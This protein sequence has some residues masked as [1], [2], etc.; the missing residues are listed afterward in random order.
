MKTYRFIRL[1]T[2][3]SVLVVSGC[4]T[5]PEDV[6]TDPNSVAVVVGS[7]IGT[8][9]SGS[10][11]GDN[12]IIGLTMF[13]HNTFDLAEGSA[14]N[15]KYTITSGA[16]GIFNAADNASIIYFPKDGSTVDF[17]S[18]YPYTPA[19]TSDYI[20]PLN[21][22]DQTALPKIDFMTADHLAGD[23]KSNPAVQLRFHH[24]LSKLV[25]NLQTQTG[26]AP[27][28]LIGSTITIKGMYTQGSYKLTNNTSGVTPNLTSMGD[29]NII[30]NASGVSAEGIVFPRAA[31]QGIVFEVTLT[32]GSRYTAYMENTLELK[33]GYQYIFY[34]TLNKTPVVVSADIQPWN[35]GPTSNLT[36]LSIAATINASSGVN[37][38]DI[39]HVYNKL[40]HI[41]QYTYGINGQW[42]SS[43]P[44]Y[45]ENLEGSSATFRAAINP[46][47]A[48]NA[49][50]LPDILVADPV[51]VA[52]NDGVNFIFRHA[53]SKV[54]VQLSSSDGSFTSTELNSATISLPSYMTGGYESLGVFV[55]GTTPQDIILKNGVALIQP[56]TIPSGNNLVKVTINGTNYFAQVPASAVIFSAGEARQI[57]LNM[58]KTR[59]LVSATVVDWVSGQNI[60]LATQYVT[61]VTPGNTL[62]FSYGSTVAMYLLNNNNTSCKFTY[63]VNGTWLPDTP[64]YW[65]NLTNVPAEI[66]A[67][68][69]STVNAPSNKIIN[70]NVS[71]DQSTGVSSSDLLVAYI[72]S[73]YAGQP[74]NL[75]FKHAMNEVV[76]ILNPGQGVT[77]SM[78]SS[79]TVLLKNMP[80][81]C[82][83]NTSTLA[84]SIIA[85]QDVKPNKTSDL[86][87]NALIVPCTI[88]A[89]TQMMTITLD[90][91]TYPVTFSSSI[92]FAASHINTLTVTINKTGIA[93]S[94]TLESW[95]S[96]SNGNAII[97]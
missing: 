43:D 16:S 13:K 89:N 53:A 78:L 1:L 94:A 70:W 21:V 30:T 41:G 17:T 62:G 68:Y 40:T 91:D 96:G 31:A 15:R 33:S 93:M 82:T 77:A 59:I 32:D 54:T 2:I 22:S 95:T 52:R 74:G 4:S 20:V 47:A 36:A 66:T 84:S 44:V 86:N 71:A 90:G 63:Q 85:S 23:S 97:E 5:S 34:I 9:A 58:L 50:Q 87:F 60:G 12:D 81:V 73:L 67:I 75:S 65:D 76:I 48:L 56:Q 29:I 10:L 27:S 51:T 18:Y 25:V 80:T 64:I 46:T 45:W 92:T 83:V 88:A 38:G 49:T 3:L 35:I 69:P 24:R 26:D 72:P 55:A 19:M 14:V 39:M 79:A 42:V 28:R 6:S 11:W 57:N 8:R 61:V 7:H 37:S